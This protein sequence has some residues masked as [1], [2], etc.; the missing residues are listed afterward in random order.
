MNHDESSNSWSI[1]GF[2]WTS[3]TSDVT[4]IMETLPFEPK[5]IPGQ[6]VT[7]PEDA[8][9]Q[10][11]Q[12]LY[13]QYPLD[14]SAFQQA[15]RD[16][17]GAYFTCNLHHQLEEFLNSGRSNS[18][19]LRWDVMNIPP[20][21]SFKLHAHPNI[22][23]IYVLAGRLYEYRLQVSLAFLLLCIIFY[24]VTSTSSFVVGGTSGHLFDTA[25]CLQWTQHG[26]I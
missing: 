2:G 25:G 26:W 15:M 7:F 9:I 19:A 18:R 24:S 10:K 5:I 21:K 23:L 4:L 1:P 8:I 3:N 16:A 11:L 12:K 22:E 20:K 17:L 13:P 6:P 14:P